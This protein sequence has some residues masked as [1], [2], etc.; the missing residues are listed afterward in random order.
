MTNKQIYKRKL[1][2]QIKYL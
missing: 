1:Y 2:S